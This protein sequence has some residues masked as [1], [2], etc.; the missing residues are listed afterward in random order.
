MSLTSILKNKNNQ[1]LRDKLKTEFVRPVF[2]LKTEIKANAL[3][4]NTQLVGTAFDYLMRF[5]LQHHNK[6]IFIQVESSWVA[7]NSY[8]ILTRKFSKNLDS[9]IKTGSQNDI[10][11]KAKDLLKIIIE[12]YDETKNNYSKFI[13]DGQL[14]DNLIANTIY[15]AKL[16]AY[17]RSKVIDQ[18]FNY[19]DP[20]DI[21]DLKALISLVDKSKFTATEKCYLNPTFGEGSSIVG[22]ADADLIIDNTLIDFKATKHLKLEREHL[23]QLLGY[24][25]LSKIGGI[26]NDKLDKPIENIGIYFARHGELWT[27]PIEEFGDSQKFEN[28]KDWFV[29]FVT[30]D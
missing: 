6:N 29:S 24:Y 11:F 12:Q 27:I 3:T 28:F 1:A 13:E 10:F 18:N 8:K 17:F 2:S 30:S 21:K 20:N 9:D 7:D 26:N 16:D 15:L 14:N 5:Y 23:N 19:H 4:N 22:G 25:I